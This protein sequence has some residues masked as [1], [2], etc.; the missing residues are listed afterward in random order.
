MGKGVRNRGHL[1]GTEPPHGPIGDEPRVLPVPVDG[2]VDLLA[3]SDGS[4]D[5]RARLVATGEHGGNRSDETVWGDL[6]D[7]GLEVDFFRIRTHRLSRGSPPP[8]P[9]LFRQ[10]FH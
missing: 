9:E 4:R 3:L 2:A 6:A 7:E 10:Q 1:W 8:C 5:G